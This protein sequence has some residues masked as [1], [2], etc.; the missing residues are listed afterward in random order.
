M[1]VK[2][3]LYKK[4]ISRGITIP[5]F[6]LFYRARVMK[7]AWYWNRNRQ[8]DQQNQIKDPN[9]NPH[10][11]EHMIFDKE[12][13]NIQ[14]KKRKHLQQIVLAQL[15]V[16][17]QKNAVSI[18]MYKTQVQVDQRPQHKSSF[19]ELDRKESRK[20]PRIQ[21]HRRLLYKY[22]TSSTDTESNN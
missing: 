14:W 13:K 22:R 9:I 5:N 16:H 20:Q 11:Y 2:T 18:P 21:G 12:A 7:T 15:D 4:G 10:T 1:V 17:M 3:I 19:T 8:V 6:K